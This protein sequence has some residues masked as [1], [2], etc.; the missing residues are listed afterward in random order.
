MT[1]YTIPKKFNPLQRLSTCP[2]WLVFGFLFL[3]QLIPSLQG[4]TLHDEGFYAVFYQQIFNDPES[5]QFNF[6]YWFSGIVGA[7][8][9]KLFPNAGLLGLRVAGILCTLAT[10][11]L[12][13]K[14]LK[15]YFKRG[16]LYTGIILAVMAL[17]NEPKELH[18][19]NLSALFY[20]ASAY[21]IFKGLR[22]NRYWP[23]I[24]AGFLLAFNMFTRIPN[25]LGI[26]MTVI[27][28]IHGIQSAT[29]WKKIIVQCALIVASFVLGIAGIIT[30]MKALGHW[31]IF[32][33]ASELL[34][35]MGKSDEGL[36]NI[37]TLI[38]M[39]IQNY[40]NSIRNFVILFLLLLLASSPGR[41][42][43][44]AGIRLNLSKWMPV[45]RYVLL[46]AFAAII[47]GRFFS[48]FLQMYIQ[49][50][51]CVISAVVIL[52]A[53]RDPNII[54]L[55]LLGL[56]IMVVYPLGSND[57]ILT[58]GMFSFWLI[59]PLCVAFW[60][61][62]NSA[63]M[64]LRLSEKDGSSNIVNLR[65]KE[66]RMH[67]I[68]KWGTLFFILMCCVNYFYYPHFD[69]K[70]RIKLTHTVDHKYLRGIHTSEGRATAIQQTLEALEKVVKKA[71]PW[72]Y[73]SSIFKEELQKAEKEK[74]QLPV[75]LTQKMITMGDGGYWPSPLVHFNS[76]TWPVNEKRNEALNDFLQRNKYNTAWE[77]DYFKISIPQ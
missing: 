52:F 13:Y 76:E 70:N 34:S 64:S 11:I 30:W 56:F 29:P 58:A 16:Y 23:F 26:G 46:A 71:W 49:S 14:L 62:P 51:F 63:G 12:V 8:W 77:N 24:A 21:L 72:L 65:I 6:M 40:V 38:N 39:F 47:I 4:L 61:E 15:P 7:A 66:E 67:L 33:N 37:F 19:N 31:E 20:V 18:Y 42:S 45:I 9:F 74:K 44:P 35:R 73:E 25:L 59:F 10:V 48:N 55:T 3:W 60:S 69:K 41:W 43:L 68:K 1:T 28:I 27:I 54:T 2:P 36:Y 17:N 22:D 57:G 50:G 32:L 5:V 75:V 53:R